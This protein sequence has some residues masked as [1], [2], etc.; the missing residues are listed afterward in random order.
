[1]N[2]WGTDDFQGC[3]AALDAAAMVVTPVGMLIVG[4]FHTMCVWEIS[5]PSPPFCCKPTPQ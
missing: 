2:W 3:E 5:V 4:I 1:M